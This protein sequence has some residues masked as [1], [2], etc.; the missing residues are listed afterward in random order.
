MTRSNDMS[1]IPLLKLLFLAFKR[2]ET[3]QNETIGYINSES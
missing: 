3:K 2:N 1:A